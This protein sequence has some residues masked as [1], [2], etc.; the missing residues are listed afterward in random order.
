MKN[1]KW[2][3]KS[4]MKNEKWKNMFKNEKI[5]TSKNPLEENTKIQKWTIQKVKKSII[6][7]IQSG[8][9]PPRTLPLVGF[10]PCSETV[11]A[12]ST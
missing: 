9:K 10:F 1:E 2:K 5:K 7:I 3:I 4:K 12:A 8:S 6:E 11:R